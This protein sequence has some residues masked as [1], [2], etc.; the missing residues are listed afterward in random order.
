[1]MVARMAFRN[2]FRQKRRSLL[3]ALMMV[4]GFVLSSISLGISD[5]SY[6]HFIDLFTRDHTGHV[7]VHRAGYLERPSLYKTFEFPDKLGRVIE[8][9]PYV[10]AWS[11]RVHSV[12][13]AFRGPKTTGVQLVGVD[14]LREAR[15][16]RL[17]H[18]VRQGR[19]IAA[20]P[21]P[22]MMVG[23]GLARILRVGP[24]DEVVLIGQAADGS[25]A[26][27]LF[28]V[29][30]VVGGS[31]AA[32]MNC[33][34][35]LQTAQEFLALGARVHE[36][37]VV[38]THQAQA[39]LMAERIQRTLDDSL[40]AVDPWQVVERQFYQAM[41]A[42]VEGMWLS[43]TII[44]SIVAIGVLNTVLMTILERTREF[45][46]LRALGTRPWAVF[47]MIVLET[48]FLAVLSILPASALSLLGNYALSI[49]GIPLPTAIEY[50]GIQWDEIISKVSFKSLWL[51]GLVV[52]VTAVVVS[53]FPALRAARI[54]PVKAMRAH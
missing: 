18:K 48:T 45:G 8:E 10:E 7:Q 27:D 46:V 23:E 33:Y 1:M 53:V 22:E 40:L 6:S 5:G 43:L 42:D 14:P 2:I 31:G 3:T 17:K 35:H 32:R 29:V 44:M 11:P 51:P 12:A 24:G 15:T 4:G 37:A 52:F 30:G 41:Q 13:L 49:Q 16:T 47:K 38:L 28:A 54:T 26:N 36:M 50:G 39:R 25:I 21:G 9:L 34:V 20:E 19:F